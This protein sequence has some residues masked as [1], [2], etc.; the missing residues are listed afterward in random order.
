MENLL[1]VTTRE[2]FRSWL[3]LNSTTEKC[4]WVIVSM[5]P[6]SNTLL[7][8][9]AVEEALCFGWIDGIKKKNEENQLVQRLSP[10]AKNSSWT[11]L[12]I[13]RAHRLE[14]IGLMTAEGRKVLP[15]LN[16]NDFKMDEQI[17]KKL[18]ESDYTYENFMKFPELYRRIRIDTINQVKNQLELFEKRLDKL[19]ENCKKGEMYGAWNDNGRLL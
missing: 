3:L 7:Y 1:K 14:R 10:R 16:G 18:K 12:N 13:E 2:G 19:I 9:D 11:Q 6:K 17:M 5:T 4:C 8:L 15:D